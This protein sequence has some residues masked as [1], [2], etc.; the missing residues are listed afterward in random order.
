MSISERVQADATI[1]DQVDQA[2]QRVETLRS[3]LQAMRNKRRCVDSQLVANLQQIQYMRTQLEKLEAQNQEIKVAATPIL[4]LV[5]GLSKNQ[6]SKPFLDQLR[7]VPDLILA[8][9]K[10]AKS[11]VSQS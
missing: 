9:Y 7:K 3:Q 8:S 10:K 1:K 5:S 2:I 6:A 11:F 4:Q